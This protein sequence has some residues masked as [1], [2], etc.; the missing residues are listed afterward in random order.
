VLFCISLQLGAMI[1]FGLFAASVVSRLQF[2]GVRAA[3]C[4]IALFG[5]FLVVFDAIVGAMVMWNDASPRGHRSSAS[6]ARAL[7]SRLWAGGP[8]FSIP[9]SLPECL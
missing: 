5:G 9:C 6:P 3:G 2:H 1:C 4:L 8:G 7:L